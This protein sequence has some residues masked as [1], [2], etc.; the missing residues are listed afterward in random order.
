[1]LWSYGMVAIAAEWADGRP[2][3]DALHADLTPYPHAAFYQ[4]GFRGT[5]PVGNG[6]GLTGA[7]MFDF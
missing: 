5:E 3:F 6:R 2:T 4:R 1:M 7:Q